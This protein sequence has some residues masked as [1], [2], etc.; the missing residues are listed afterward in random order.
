MNGELKNE[1][2]KTNGMWRK[3]AK[4][5]DRGRKDEGREGATSR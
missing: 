2:G 3:R 5:R 4:E 1:V